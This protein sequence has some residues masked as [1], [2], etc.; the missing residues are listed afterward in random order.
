MTEAEVTS[1]G[2]ADSFLKA[3]HLARTRH[4]HQVSLLSLYSLQQEAFALT[5]ADELEHSVSKEDWLN[6]MS[7]RSPNFLYWCMIMKYETLILFL[8][9]AEELFI[10]R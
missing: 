2:K 7:N 5:F 8:V 10:V 9:R 3:T 4:T 6:Q 1:S